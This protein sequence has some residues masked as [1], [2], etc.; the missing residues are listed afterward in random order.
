[1]AQLAILIMDVGILAASS[2]LWHNAI[3]EIAAGPVLN[4]DNPEVRV[5]AYLLS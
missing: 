1:M 2:R 4:L 5:E 3:K